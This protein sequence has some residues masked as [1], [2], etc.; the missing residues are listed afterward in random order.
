MSKTP[1]LYKN[2]KLNSANFGNFNHSDYQVFLYL[3]SKI[4]GI[5]QKGRYLRPEQLKREYILTAKEISNQFN[6]AMTNSYQSVD[7]LMNTNL[8]IKRIEDNE[9]WKINIC[10]I[11]K[12]NKEQG[13]IS[14]KFTDDIMPYLAQVKE[15]FVLYNLKEVTQFK[16]LY[17]TRFY[18][19]MQEFKETG[20]MTK[21]IAQLKESFGVGEFKLKKYNDFKKYTFLRAIEEIN[22]LY[23]INIKFEEIKEVRK[24]IAIKFFFEKAKFVEVYDP[25]TNTTSKQYAKIKPDTTSAPITKKQKQTKKCKIKPT[26]ILLNLLALLLKTNFINYFNKLNF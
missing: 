8:K 19:L 14:I 1:K 10:S 24:V 4:A 17:T 5:D 13:N 20:W 12:Y 3:I 16:S 25:I 23:K 21:S 7:K 18:E 22:N 11:A 26:Q 2:K 15:K 9:M 6:A